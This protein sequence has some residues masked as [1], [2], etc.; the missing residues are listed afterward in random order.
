MS[1]Y[2]ELCEAY[3]NALSRTRETQQKCIKFADTFFKQMSDY[4]SYSFKLERTSF[5]RDNKMRIETSIIL[6][7]FPDN[8]EAGSQERIILN[9]SLK[10]ILDN[11]I[12][13]LD[14]WSEEHKLFEDEFDKFEEVYEFIFE[15][16]REIYLNEIPLPE[17]GK[18]SVRDFIMPF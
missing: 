11:Y 18:S 5:D 15:K 10:K 16:I 3:A 8:P 17:D 2:L 12:L 14:S 4:F 1:K 13:T 9:F 7:E 6:S